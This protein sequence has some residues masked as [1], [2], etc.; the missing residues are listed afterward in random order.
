MH[1][2]IKNNLLPILKMHRTKSIFE[3]V[4]NIVNDLDIDIKIPIL[5]NKQ[6]NRSNHQTAT[7]EEYYR[8]SLF[9]HI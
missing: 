3:I 5:T 1:H 8:V 2:H 4:K 6:N 9:Y 7:P